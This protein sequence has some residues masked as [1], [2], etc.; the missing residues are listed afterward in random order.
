MRVEAALRR[1]ATR[2]DSLKSEPYASDIH[3]AQPS[4]RVWQEP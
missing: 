1:Y 3:A 4:A 2:R